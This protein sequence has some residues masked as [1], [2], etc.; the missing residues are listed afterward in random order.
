RLA[1]GQPLTLVREPDNPHDR[2]A[3]RID[4]RNEKLGYVP[5]E[6]NA[7][8]AARLDAGE[9]LHARITDIDFEAEP[10]RRV[11]FVVEKASGVQT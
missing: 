8:I 6:H 7:E 11:R 10:W 4:W 5:R 3:V 1:P 9:D 2:R